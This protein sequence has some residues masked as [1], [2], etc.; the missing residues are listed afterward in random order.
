[1]RLCSAL[2]AITSAFALAL[3][4]ATAAQAQD[5]LGLNYKYIDTAT[6]AAASATLPEQPPLNECILIQEV[7]EL[8]PG[9]EHA[10]AFAPQNTS[11]RANAQIFAA[12]D[13]TGT[14][15]VVLKPGSDQEPDDV[16]FRSVKFVLPG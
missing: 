9:Q 14:P 7:A 13:C 5:E 2:L 15:K 4:S 12:D 3:P 1:M 6:G 8:A 16:T 10:D 11:S